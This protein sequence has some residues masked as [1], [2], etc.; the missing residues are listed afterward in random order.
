MKEYFKV[1]SAADFDSAKN[2]S[3]Q[4][5]KSAGCC[6]WEKDE[7]ASFRYAKFEMLIQVL[8]YLIDLHNYLN[9]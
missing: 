2:I 1:F 8:V 3:K 6:F 5:N 4:I 9:Y 7:E